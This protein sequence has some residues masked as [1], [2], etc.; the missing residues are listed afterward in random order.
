[1]VLCVFSPNSQS[2]SRAADNPFHSLAGSDVQYN[3]PWKKE[4]K[5]VCWTRVDVTQTP[6]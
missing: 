3:V 1:M 4:V 6:Q 2:D 5:T